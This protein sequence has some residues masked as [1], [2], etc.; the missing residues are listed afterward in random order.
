MKIHWLNAEKTRARLVKGW[1]RKRQAIV[2]DD[3]R[4]GGRVK[5]SGFCSFLCSQYHHQWFF[6]KNNTECS[7]A[8]S[9]R[10][11]HTKEHD[12]KIRDEKE[13]W[14]HVAPV[15]VARALP[16]GTQELWMDN[17]AW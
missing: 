6:E 8:L 17:I 12:N 1:F 15:P 13:V 7:D 4:G 16:V 14:E 5:C 3:P 9:S 2:F 10:L 11:E